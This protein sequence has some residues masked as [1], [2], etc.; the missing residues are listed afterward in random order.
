M[1]DTSAAGQRPGFI[2]DAAAYRPVPPNLTPLCARRFT[3][4][5]ELIAASPGRDGMSLSE[6]ITA[7]AGDLG[8]A[9]ATIGGLLD[10]I[11]Q[12]SFDLDLE[13][14]RTND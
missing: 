10:I 3:E 8:A 4:A 14:E 6:L 2:Y 1:T 9:K 5:M 12:L 11:G 7:L 13:R